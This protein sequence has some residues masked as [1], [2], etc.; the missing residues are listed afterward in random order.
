[1]LLGFAVRLGAIVA[2]S[3]ITVTWSPFKSTTYPYVVLQPS[4]YKYVTFQNTAGHDVDYFFPSLG[5]QITSVSI[6]ADGTMS[7][8]AAG[9]QSLGAKNVHIAAKLPVDGKLRTLTAGDF[10]GIPGQWTIEQ[11]CFRDAGQV[12][13][14]TLSYD[15]RYRDQRHIMIKILKSF[16]PR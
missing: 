16:H 14:L 1:M 5:S 15:H 6:Y 9:L 8:V 3:G 11:M 12:W 10:S 2:F 4:S 13:H 7:S